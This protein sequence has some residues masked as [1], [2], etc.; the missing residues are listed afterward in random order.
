MNKLTQQILSV[1]EYVAQLSTIRS[2]KENQVVFRGHSDKSYKIQP[3]IFR[4][5]LKLKEH[6]GRILRELISSHP[7]EF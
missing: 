5:D 3:S 4:L 2:A 6:E 7:E 1:S